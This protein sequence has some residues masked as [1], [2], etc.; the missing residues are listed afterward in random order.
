MSKALSF[1][2]LDLVGIRTLGQVLTE[3]PHKFLSQGVVGW[4]KELL[5][6]ILNQLGAHFFTISIC[7]INSS[8]LEVLMRALHHSFAAYNLIGRGLH[9]RRVLGVIER[10]SLNLRLDAVMR[11]RFRSLLE[12][13]LLDR[14]DQSFICADAR[15]RCRNLRLHGLATQA[16]KLTNNLEIGHC[17]RNI[18]RFFL[19][20]K[21]GFHDIASDCSFTRNLTRNALEQ[22]TS[23]RVGIDNI[24][25]FGQSSSLGTRRI[26]LQCFEIAVAVHRLTHTRERRAQAAR[27][28]MRCRF[29]RLICCRV[30][31]T[32][33]SRID[34]RCRVALAEVGRHRLCDIANAIVAALRRYR[35]IA[36]A[37][38]IAGN[39]PCNTAF[40]ALGVSQDVIH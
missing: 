27:I 8:L 16:F 2:I 20:P 25:P 15:R 30:L 38:D 26:V 32:V 3:H 18:C 17:V 22:R 33:A 34:E 35:T 31:Y 12:K 1:Q 36:R 39:S 40:N 37:G 10:N 28:R 19:P 23:L 9:I 6:G 7:F 24:H 11:N 4:G 14:S 21:F 29:R 13:I 5:H